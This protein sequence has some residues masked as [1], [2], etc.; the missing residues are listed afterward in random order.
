M[1]SV[2]IPAYNSAD[3]IARTLRSITGQ[4]FSDIEILVVND[5]STDAT[6][7]VVSA[8]IEKD[9][10]IKLFTIP[11]GGAFA[12]RLYG[13]RHSRGEW[14]AFSDSDDTM[15]INSL[16]L[17]SEFA[18]ETRDIVVGNLNLNNK[19]L[20][21][22]RITGE[23]SGEEYSEAILLGKTSL[24][25]YGKL[26]RPSL[27]EDLHPVPANIRLNEDMLMLL[28]TA[29]KARRIFISNEIVTYNYLYRA[30]GVSKGPSMPLKDWLDLFKL[31]ESAIRPS[32]PVLYDAFSI[33]RLRRIYE[34]V[35]LEGTFVNPSDP[36]IAGI[37]NDCKKISDLS[38]DDTSYLRTLQS[39]SLQ[40]K[41]FSI[42]N[43]KR[44]VK[45]WIKKFIGWKK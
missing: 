12:A 27:F 45:D 21:N 39:V 11:N 6:A 18:D 1:I 15:P 19:K 23:I 36:V 9:P 41:A 14:I 2:V 40:K 29:K 33:M 37:I 38:A 25:N 20:F 16:S 24:G 4:T 13:V 5:G 34:K 35:L 8:L 32:T 42:H 17:L 28:N 26:Y 44:Q 3:Y 30:G 31:I 10:R 22:H 43:M 7:E